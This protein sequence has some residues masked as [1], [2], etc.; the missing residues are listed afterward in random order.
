MQDSSRLLTGPFVRLLAANFCFFLTFASFFLLPLHV[1]ALGGDERVI[2]LVMGTAGIA[3]L[4]SLFVAGPLLDRFGR[5]P[6]LLGGLGTMAMVTAGFLVVD[7]IGPALFLLRGLQGLAFA[8][9]FN[10]AS[11]LAVEFAPPA[12]R[13]AALGIF[14]VSTLATHALAPA[15][16]EIL[17][18]RRGFPALFEVAAA[19]SVVAL[20]LAWSLDVPPPLHGARSVRLRP[21]RTL[22]SASVTVAFCGV[23]FGAVL[24][25][26]PTFVEDAHLGRVG[27]FFLC[28]TG[29]AVLTR[30]TAGSLGDLFDRRAVILPALGLLAASIVGLAAVRTAGGL[31]GAGLLFGLAQGIS[32]PTLNAFAIDH[33]APETLGRA[34]TLYNGAFNVGVTSGSIALGTVVQAAGHRTMFLCAAA[35]AAAAFAVF[36]V[37]TR[38]SLDRAPSPAG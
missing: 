12:R 7:R 15:L 2:G 36:L 16:G 4:A 25:Y 3:G 33:I 19:C 28:Y 17:V 10:A 6:F 8:A 21:T 11:T 31:A 23:A 38:P 35:I 30:V 13:A 5:R 32:Y 24:T 20:L 14:G 37:G 26:V 9:G 29:A 18:R 22:A 27:T 1:R 34:Q